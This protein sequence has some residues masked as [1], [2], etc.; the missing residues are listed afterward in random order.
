MSA[1]EN[2]SGC[3]WI[4]HRKYHEYVFETLL[5]LQLKLDAHVILPFAIMVC[6]YEDAKE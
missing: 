3:K 1:N 6:Y 5:G 2:G 4:V